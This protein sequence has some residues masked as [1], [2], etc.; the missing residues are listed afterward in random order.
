MDRLREGSFRA[1]AS[2][3]ARVT[4]KARVLDDEV[5][6][7]PVSPAGSAAGLSDAELA[8][9]RRKDSESSKGES[10]CDEA[11]TADQRRRDRDPLLYGRLI[12][13]YPRIAF[14]RILHILTSDR[15]NTMEY[16]DALSNLF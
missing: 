11:E 6:L 2:T 13:E 7:V 9:I 14:G 4:E 5:T 16:S 10:R 8:S 3:S 12:V 1:V 15:H